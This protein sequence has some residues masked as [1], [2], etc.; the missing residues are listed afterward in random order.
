MFVGIG[1]QVFTKLKLIEDRL[2][3]KP[4]PLTNSFYYGV[5]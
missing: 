4:K 1:W 3:A 2:K 5:E